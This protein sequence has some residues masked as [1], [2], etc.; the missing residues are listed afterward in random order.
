MP[1]FFET[2]QLSEV[3]EQLISKAK[4]RLQKFYNPSLYKAEPKKEMTMEEKIIAS[5]SS[6]LVQQEAAFDG[7]SFVQVRLHRRDATGVAPPEAPE[8]F[9]KTYKKS[10]KSG[11]VMALMDMI[12]NEL[13]ASLQ[14]AKFAEKSAQKE[15]VEL[16]QDSQEKRA[17]DSKSIVGANGAKAA[18]EGT[19]SDAKEN[20]MLTVEQQANVFSTLAKLHGSCDFILKNM[21][22]RL[23]ARTAEIEGLKNA[24]AVLAGANFS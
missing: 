7:A 9:D 1:I 2:V 22:L 10:E 3:A 15:Y 4:N 16:M 6:A 24:K 23:S 17:Q 8:T 19:L 20:Q 11:G 14:E 5:G 18:L 12:V 13:K 21:E